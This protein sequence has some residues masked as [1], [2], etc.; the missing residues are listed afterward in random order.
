MYARPPQRRLHLGCDARNDRQE[1]EGVC[2]S[3]FR[4]G[5]IWWD[6]VLITEIPEIDER[7]TL[8][9]IGASSSDVVPVFLCGQSAYAKATGQMPIPTRRDETDYQFLTG[10]GIEVSTALARLPRFRLAARRSR[11]GAW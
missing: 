5:D 7:L 11:I 4:N 3:L 6:N 8:T 1:R 10:M 9:G 2:Q